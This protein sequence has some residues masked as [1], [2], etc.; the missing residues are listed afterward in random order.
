MI[1]KLSLDLPE[2][3]HYIRI[4]RLL[5]RTLLEHLKVVEQDIDEVEVVVGELC[6]NVLLHAQGS[7]GRFRV[8]MEYHQDRVV[9]LVED[10]GQG[11]SF[12]DMPDV[13][14]QRRDI[15]GEERIGGYGLTIVDALSDRLEFHRSDP[16]GT[17]V[18]AEK[19]LHF[20]T[21]APAQPPDSA[22]APGNGPA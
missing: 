18:R 4:T 21:N 2:G 19:W 3:H 10:T 7:S 5:G 9:V 13:G 16:Q 11:F 14:A 17:T 22:H 20:V 8:T 1:L 15:H 6:T 12:A